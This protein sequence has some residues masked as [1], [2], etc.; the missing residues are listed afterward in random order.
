ASSIVDYELIWK[1]VGF[2]PF[3]FNIEVNPIIKDFIAAKY[4]DKSLAPFEEGI[5]NLINTA[6]TEQLKTVIRTT[7]SNN[8]DRMINRK[9]DYIDSCRRTIKEYTQSIENQ[10]RDLAKCSLEYESLLLQKANMNE[11]TENQ[12][13][14]FVDYLL[15]LKHVKVHEVRANYNKIYLKF[16]V[17]LT[18]YDPEACERILR[19]LNRQA[20]DEN[21]KRVIRA[22]QKILLEEEYTMTISAIVVINFEDRQIFVNQNNRDGYTTL[23]NPHLYHFNCWGDNSSRIYDAL[24]KGELET[25]VNFISMAVQNINFTDITVINR[26]IRTLESEI[27][28]IP[29]ATNFIDMKSIKDTDGIEYTLREIIEIM[30]KEGEDL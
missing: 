13:N 16:E 22:L 5:R 21:Y 30:E 12:T 6:S 8:I 17:P 1:I 3:I 14:S 28:E 4:S 26:W 15:R 20:E 11:N 7:I 18:S 29:A 24:S 25:M 9:R 19:S 2:F 23:Y 27:N 10:Y